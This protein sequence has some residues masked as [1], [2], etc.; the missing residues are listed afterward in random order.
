MLLLLDGIVLGLI[1]GLVTRGTVGNLA[2]AK[3]KGEVA[4]VAILVFQVSVPRLTT[5]FGLTG[6]IPLVLWL[7]SMVALVGLALVNWRSAGMVLAAIGIMLNIVAIG[8][9]GAM[10]VSLEA[11]AAVDSSVTPVFDLLHEPVTE[12]TRL[13]GLTD[14]IAMPGPVWHRGIA[15]IGDFFLTLGAGLYLFVAMHEESSEG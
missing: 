10:P 5:L 6:S 8:L 9:N 12:K 11:I 4:L 2:H 15:S 7:L 13:V 3:L 14:V 1:L